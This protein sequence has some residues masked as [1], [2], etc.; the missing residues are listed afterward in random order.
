MSQDCVFVRARQVEVKASKS[1]TQ[2]RQES[3]FKK[4][5]MFKVQDN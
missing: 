2:H 1:E 5:E 3:Y 4:H